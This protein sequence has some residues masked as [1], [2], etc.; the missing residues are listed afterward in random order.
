MTEVLRDRRTGWLLAAMAAG[1]AWWWL[2]AGRSMGQMFVCG[3]DGYGPADGAWRVGRLVAL[4]GMWVVMMGTMGAASSLFSPAGRRWPAGPDEGAPRVGRPLIA[5]LRSALLPAGEKWEQAAPSL[6]YLIGYL[7][8]IA[9]VSVAAATSQWVLE[10]TN[11]IGEGARLSSPILAGMLLTSIG[12]W[13]VAQL[14]RHH[15]TCDVTDSPHANSL[16]QG[17]QHGCASLNC[18]LT[19]IGLQFVVGAM[20]ATLMLTLTLWMLAEALLPWKR[21]LASATGIALL[22]YGGLT[23]MGALA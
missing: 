13:H 14:L 20:N 2:L 11:L 23:I 7:V 5:S 18:C 19:M 4:S 16:L 3:V 21:E 10:S 17:W 22:T 15:V 6:C 12:L 8:F 9:G 1:G